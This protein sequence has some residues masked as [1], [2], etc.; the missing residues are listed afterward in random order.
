M[1]HKMWMHVWIFVAALML[2]VACVEAVPALKLFNLGVGLVAAGLALLHYLIRHVA[3]TQRR[4]R[5]ARQRDSASVREHDEQ[6]QR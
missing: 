4:A 2:A 6:R 3:L 1:S 5:S